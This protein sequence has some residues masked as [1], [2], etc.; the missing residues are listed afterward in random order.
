MRTTID[1]PD[2]LMRQLK[3][4]AALEGKKLKEIVIEALRKEVSGSNGAG[5]GR[6][7]REIPV[8]IETP[9]GYEIATITNGEIDEV[10]DEEI[11]RMVNGPS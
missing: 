10:D 11:A 5:T 9:A 7:K 6:A 1:L 4:R 8:V 2:D 3:V